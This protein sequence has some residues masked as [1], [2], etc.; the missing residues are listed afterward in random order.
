[1]LMS[2]ATLFGTN[3]VAT[4]KT[5]YTGDVSSGTAESVNFAAVS[6]SRAN[7]VSGEPEPYWLLFARA[8]SQDTDFKSF[9]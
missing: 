6:W 5:R 7:I 4:L 2:R 3:T 1:M 9:G 8:K